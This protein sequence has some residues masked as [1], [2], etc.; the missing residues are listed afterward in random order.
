MMSAENGHVGVVQALTEAGASTDMQNRV[1]LTASPSVLHDPTM[2]ALVW[3][4]SSLAS[5]LEKDTISCL[6]GHS[7]FFGTGWMDGAGICRQERKP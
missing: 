5:E 3:V 2:C 4:H 1:R 7:E 6:G